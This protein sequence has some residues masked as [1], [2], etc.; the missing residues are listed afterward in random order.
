VRLIIVADIRFYREGLALFF[1][2]REGFEVTGTAEDV[3]GVV[4]LGRRSQF[5][6]ALLDMAT[7]GA[8]MAVEVL[9]VVSPKGGIVALGV[10][11]DEQEVISL[12]EAGVDGF[13]ARDTSLEDLCRAV[14][15]AARGETQCS[16][17]VSG[18]L[19]RRVATLAHQ[20]PE[21]AGVPLT[22]R[23][24]EIVKLIDEG[25]PNKLIAQRL[26]IEV[27]TVKNHVHNILQR[28]GVQHRQD[29]ADAV[30]RLSEGLLPG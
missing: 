13:V 10:R 3:A 14:E 25:L 2:E 17:R 16:P 30:R 20:L 15:S 27:S 22:R 21:R 4:D 1:R 26:F 24:L 9:R 12:A 23:Q 29:A 11:E 28:L 18:M 6:V 8:S 19:A 5:D 7:A